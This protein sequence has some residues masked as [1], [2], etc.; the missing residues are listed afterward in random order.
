MDIC[1]IIHAIL[2]RS[3]GC[4]GVI[5]ILLALASII[6]QTE[7]FLINNNFVFLGCNSALIHLGLTF[8][9]S[10]AITTA[11]KK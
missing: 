10:A 8:S 7:F 5:N 1:S 6:I 3:Q 2:L 11:A 4:T 9:S